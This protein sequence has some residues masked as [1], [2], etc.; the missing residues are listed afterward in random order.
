ML[1]CVSSRGSSRFTPVSVASDQLTC[2]PEPLIP[3]KGFSCSRQ[4]KPVAGA[5]RRRVSITS[6]WWSDA[7][8]AV[9][10]VGRDLELARGDLVVARLDRNAQAVE[11]ALASAMNASTRGGI[12]PEVVV[13]ELLV[14]GRAGAEAASAR[15]HQVGR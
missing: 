7:T 8:L 13:L 1:V 11:L 14:L 12:A 10:K 6:I 5:T 15:T 3:A 2:L 9:S 4:A